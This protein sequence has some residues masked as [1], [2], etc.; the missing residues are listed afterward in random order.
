MSLYRAVLIG[1]AAVIA[2]VILMVVPENV[3]FML[4]A[5]VWVVGLSGLLG[6]A[7]AVYV[8]ASLDYL[9]DDDD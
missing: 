4:G 8:K 3:Q 6:L 5:M 1:Y 2:Q 9:K 7:V